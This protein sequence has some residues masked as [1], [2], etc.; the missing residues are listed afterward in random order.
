VNDNEK[1]IE[2]WCN[3]GVLFGGGAEWCGK[4]Q[5]AVKRLF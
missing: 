1:M 5:G 4:V 2:K 3:S